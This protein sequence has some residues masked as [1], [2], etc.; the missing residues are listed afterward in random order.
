MND[1]EPGSFS[2]ALLFS[3]KNCCICQKSGGDL[4][5][6]PKTASFELLIQSVTSRALYGDQRGKTV[7]SRLGNATAD[8][9]IK[10]QVKWHK[11]C[12][13]DMTHKVHI[14]RLKSR[15]EEALRAGEAP[16]KGIKGRPMARTHITSPQD[17]DTGSLVPYTRSQSKAYDTNA[18]FFCDGKSEK[19]HL[20]QISAFNTGDQ[21]RKVVES[22]NNEQWKVNLSAA[23]YPKD[24]RAIDIKYH[25]PCWVKHVQ[26]SH[27]DSPVELEEDQAISKVSTDIEF[28]YFMNT[29]LDSGAILDIADVQQAYKDIATASGA[30]DPTIS[31]R[32][33]KR[34]L[35][36]NVPDIEFCRSPR[37]N[38]PDRVYSSKTK[39]TAIDDLDKTTRDASGDMRVVF[40]CARI[41]RHD[42]ATSHKHQPWKFTDSLAEQDHIP[43]SLETLIRWILI[44][45]RSSLEST[46]REQSVQLLTKTIAQNI[47]FAYKSD[48]QASHMPKQASSS[49]WHQHENPQVVGLGLKVHQATRSKAEVDMLHKFGY[50]ISYERVLRIE[51]QLAAA[52]LKQAA[53]NNGIY[54]P[55]NLVRGRF[56]FFAIDN[57][58]FDEDTPDG[59]HTLHATATAVFQFKDTSEPAKETILDIQEPTNEKSLASTM[60]PTSPQL[61]PCNVRAQQKPASSTKYSDFT[62]EQNPD[63]LQ[64]YKAAEL[65]W[66]QLRH[67]QRNQMTS[68]KCANSSNAD[69]LDLETSTDEAMDTSDI[70]NNNQTEPLTEKDVTVQHT[71]EST[72]IQCDETQQKA[73]VIHQIVPPWS[74]FNFL[75]SSSDTALTSV[76]ALPLVSAPAHEFQT[77]LTVIKQAEE[78]NRI[79]VG[80]NR[81]VVITLDMALYER[82]KR[83]QMLLQ[84]CKEKWVLRIG[85]FHTVLC[86]LCAIG[87]A[88]EGS[89]IDDAWVMADIYGPVTTRKILEGKHMKRSVDAHIMTLQVFFDLYIEAFFEEQ[90]ALQDLLKE[91]LQELVDAFKGRNASAVSQKHQY[92]LECMNQHDLHNKLTQF[93]EHHKEN[94]MFV[95]TLRYMDMVLT[96]LEF[97]RA[98]R[99]GLWSLHLSSME[100]L[101][102]HFF[103]NNR[104]KYA[105]M[106][107]LYLAEM[108]SLEES[109]PDIWTEFKKGHFCIKKSQVPFCSIGVDHALEHVN[110]TMKVKGGLSGITQKPA[111]LLRFFLIAPELTRLSEEVM[112]MVGISSLQRTKH[113]ELSTAITERQERSIQKL[114]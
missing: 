48:R 82:A 73:E 70:V 105:Q 49:F 22:S 45:P 23:V 111:A 32:N 17:N 55:E 56:L 41:I 18:C 34:K 102:K 89:G 37:V 109:D 3:N 44:G 24:A 38:Q 99:A 101:C 106:V 40:D 36:E 21:L 94:P 65:S 112:Q 104:L 78:I 5:Q 30:E 74:G 113:H 47:M 35:V 61:L 80:P 29:L 76:H 4:V 60:S 31:R 110:R 33:I 91:P 96:L 69:F 107:P 66:L 95:V 59:K 26:R 39:K 108:H 42:I 25:L 9:L 46:Q 86:A 79:V 19:G 88:I 16:R 20:H 1:P 92:L 85:E 72:N 64:K 28:N 27:K 10:N 52:V 51:T 54:I 7:Q 2:P 43:K 8:I 13:K 103:A 14:E 98:T 53:R 77:L 83:L 15:Y 93:E 100:G 58:D 87:S 68:S 75:C 6:K 81:K 67:Y 12:Y 114:K 90:S 11:V 62:V 84:D 71:D 57:V 63:I 97:I 50:S